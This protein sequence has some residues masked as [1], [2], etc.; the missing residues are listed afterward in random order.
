M[1]WTRAMIAVVAGLV[2]SVGLWMANGAVMAPGSTTPPPHGQ[3]M[4]KELGLTPDQTAKFDQLLQQHKAAMKAEK[5]RFE[6]QVS[7]ILKPDQQAKFK[8]LMARRAEWKKHA[9]GPHEGGFM[10]GLK[11]LNLTPDQETQVKK[12]MEDSRAKLAGVAP[13]DVTAR[14][15]IHQETRAQIEKVLTPEQLSRWNEM[16]KE[17]KAHREGGMCVCPP[18]GS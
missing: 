7:G 17:W 10:M 6:S 3:Y 15:Q 18:K 4:A 8:E 11:Q 16:K 14:R 1:F 2:M 12:I 13:G 9:F 5:E